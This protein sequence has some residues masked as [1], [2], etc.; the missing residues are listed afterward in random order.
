[1]ANEKT[2]ERIKELVR[3]MP[4]TYPDLK[5]M[6]QD[7]LPV[8]PGTGID[9]EW[10][11]MFGTSVG[12]LFKQYGTQGVFHYD[13]MCS[14]V[15][16]LC[17]CGVV[18][19]CNGQFGGRNEDVTVPGYTKEAIKAAVELLKRHEEERKALRH[20]GEDA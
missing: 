9:A 10:R 5:M 16:G 20:F 13:F 1:M 6:L 17:T 7:L 15:D 19:Y 4:G 3:G 14:G 8:I 2:K 12:V 18:S 11:P